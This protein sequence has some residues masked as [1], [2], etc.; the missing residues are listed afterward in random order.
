MLHRLNC[1]IIATNNYKKAVVIISFPI[2]FS[3]S[4][5]EVI[6]STILQRGGSPNSPQISLREYYGG[7]KGNCRAKCT[8]RKL[9]SGINFDSNF[10][11]R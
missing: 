8:G 1:V 11:Q 9:M 3:F 7:N 6:P 10:F 4:P 5:A 2:E